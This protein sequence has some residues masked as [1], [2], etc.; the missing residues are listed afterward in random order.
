MVAQEMDRPAGGT[1]AADPV[2]IRPCDGQQ[3]RRL[4]EILAGVPPAIRACRAALSGTGSIKALIR[5]DEQGE[6][7]WAYGGD[8]GDTPNDRQFCLN[9][10]VF[11][12]RTPHPALFEAQ[13][14]QQLFRFTFDAAALTLTVTSDYLFRHTDN[15]Q[16]NWRLELDGVERASGS[17]DLALPPQGS[18]RFTLL[19]RLPMLHQPGELWLNVEVVQPQAT[20]WSEAHHRCAWDQWALP[21]ALP[22]TLPP[23]SAC[24]PQLETNHNLVAV[25]L[26]HS[27][28]RWHFCRRS[29]H[30][31]QWW[32][33]EQPQLLTPLR[34]G[35]ARAP[36]DNDIGVSEADHID[37]NA[38]VE[39]WK[40][41]GLYR[42]EERCTRLQ[43]EA[44]Q[45]GVRVVSEHGHRVLGEGQH[46]F[47]S[48]K[49]YGISG[50]GELTISV[51]VQQAADLPPPARIGLR[52]QLAQV[53]HQ[54]SWLGL[55][56]HEN[57]P[58]R[59]L[60]AQF[61][62]ALA[63]A[64]GGAQHTPYI[65]PGENGLRCDT[66]SLRY[67]SWRIG[68]DFPFSLSRYGLQQLM[69]CSHLAPSFAAGRSRLL[70]ASRRL[71][72]G[73]GRRRFVE[74]ERQ[75]GVFAF[76]AAL[77]LCADAASAGLV[78]AAGLRGF[79]SVFGRR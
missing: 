15:E 51:D 65:F 32:Q 54:V 34:D 60:A 35:F 59:Q 68:G 57:Y 26:T 18:A 62:R 40:L 76:S 58:D 73:R 8:F 23:L 43:A 2:R 12:D 6:E 13:R 41:A 14:A 27:D 31:T 19:D 7:C 17:L 63:A 22:V 77:A 49:R 28:Q 66:R 4:C 5:R 79:S 25:T 11:A 74:P 24:A 61:S 39:R 52:C 36:I 48:H 53:P 47:T 37:P 45:H 70:A 10:L 30:L 3:L 55:G 72:H 64:A 1:A 75:P 42:L 69:A 50:D 9:G 33:N 21:A 78:A 16:L 38:W 29:G 67:G 20:D 56:P 71:P 44:L 46:L